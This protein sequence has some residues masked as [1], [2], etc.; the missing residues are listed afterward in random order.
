MSTTLIIFDLDK[1][2]WNYYAERPK[3]PFTVIS[4]DTIQTS[5]GTNYSLHVGA[6][7]VIDYVLSRPNEYTARI[8]SACPA[9]AIAKQLL[10]LYGFPTLC[11]GS[12]IYSGNKTSHL[13]SIE[14]ETSIPLNSK[15]I[16]LDDNKTFCSQAEKLGVSSC[17]VDPDVGLNMFY[18]QRGLSLLESKNKSANLMSNWTKAPSTGSISS[19]GFT[20]TTGS[21]KRSSSSSSSSSSIASFF[22]PNTTTLSSSKRSKTN[23]K[24]TKSRFTTCPICTQNIV[25][26]TANA[27][28]MRCLATQSNSSVANVATLS[29]TSSSTSSSTP[30]NNPSTFISKASSSHLLVNPSSSST[31][32]NKTKTINILMES[33]KKLRSG[34]KFLGHQQLPGLH[35]FENFISL[36]EEKELIRQIEESQPPFKLSHWNGKHWNKEWGTEIRFVG[37]KH[38]GAIDDATQSKH[39]PQ[40]LQKVLQRFTSGEYLPT[41]AFQPNNCNAI[42]YE[43]S[44]NGHY[45]GAHFD[46]R[47]L[48]GELLANVSM[49]CDATMVYVNPETNQTVEVLLPRRSLQVVTG[50]SRYKWKHSIPINKF[51]GDTRYSLTFRCQGSSNVQVV[52]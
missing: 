40:F 3:P 8:A 42:K 24:T 17:L 52:N 5:D 7:E 35:L 28:V 15:T 48:S 29:S 45:L 49:L 34:R 9:T 12:Q 47:R 44:K 33:A 39:L 10:K 51:K 19:I 43:V 26:S 13:K 22:A 38:T 16:F 25:M 1:T 23:S 37:A 30:Y 2:I 41:A 11:K 27:H 20:D 21:K 46:D 4:K 36:D 31:T 32:K 18:F 50:E 14:K 6:R